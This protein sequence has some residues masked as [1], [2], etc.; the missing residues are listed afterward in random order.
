[1]D[2]IS[3]LEHEFKSSGSEYYKKQNE[4]KDLEVKVGKIDVK[5]DTLLNTLNEE[6]NIT[7]V[8][9][10]HNMDEAVKA[11]RV[12]V[13]DSGKII[14]DDTPRNV[15]KNVDMLRSIGLDVPQ[16]TLLA[17][18]LRKCGFD[19]RDDVLTVDECTEEIFRLCQ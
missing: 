11:G 7:I 6:Y 16:A 9:I 8:L 1:M 18:E 4:L 14:I 17:H 3:T 5:L 13:I 10:T 15:F 2:E 12:V 19:V